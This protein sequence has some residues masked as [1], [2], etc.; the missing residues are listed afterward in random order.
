MR[1]SAI[2]AAIVALLVAPSAWAINSTSGD[3][4]GYEAVH[5]TDYQAGYETVIAASLY[6]HHYSS[7]PEHVRFSPLVA[8]E[9]RRADGW[10]IGAA[11]FRNSFGQF[12]Q[13]AYGGYLWNFGNS[14]LYGKM[15]AGLMHGYTGKYQHRV[16]LNYRGFSPG[17]IPALGYKK[18]PLRLESQFIWKSGV[19]LTA[20]FAFH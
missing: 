14:G 13:L 15:T 18:G 11:L 10:L 6:N 1:H 3:E 9:L 4:T 17:A 19:M 2:G 20:G 5:K 16:P 7:S 12:T 8:L